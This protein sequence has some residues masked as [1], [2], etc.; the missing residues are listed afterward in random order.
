MQKG[1]PTGRLTAE[2]LAMPAPHAVRAIAVVRL[3]D[4]RGSYDR[5][6]DGDEEGLHDLRVALRRLRSWL[7]AYRPEMRDTLRGKTR[8]RLTDL[9]AA[10][11][12]ARDAEVGL[13]WIES[14]EDMPPRSGTGSRCIVGALERERD[15][16]TRDVKETLASDLPKLTRKLTSQLEVYWERQRLD[17]TSSIRTMAPVVAEVLRDHVQRLGRAIGRIESADDAAGVHRARI[18]AKRLRYLLEPMDDQPGVIDPLE[19][20]KV[21]QQLLGEAHDAHRLAARLVR[22]IGERAA[23]DARRRA[24]ASLEIGDEEPE[25]PS[26]TSI[27]PGLIEL[28]RRSHAAERAA[29]GRFAKAWPKRELERMTSDVQ[30]VA[31]ALST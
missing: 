21:L 10:T 25:R 24:L 23:R 2:L 15:A 14:Q 5:F 30:A 31:D 28:A 29:F 9:A 20:L 16:A 12:G 3:D 4:V 22:E 6:L 13:A 8:R 26:F 17:H 27:R 7:R 1:A 19:K 18:A 11:N